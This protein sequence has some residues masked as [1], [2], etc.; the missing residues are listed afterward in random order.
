MRDS[1]KDFN[2][3]I[4]VAPMGAYISTSM[5]WRTSDADNRPQP[6]AWLCVHEVTADA[7]IADQL[8]ER[9]APGRVFGSCRPSA[10]RQQEPR[11]RTSQVRAWAP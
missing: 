1:D 9:I 11:A 4:P 3:S 10:V 8:L 7:A 2:R 6:W 5:D